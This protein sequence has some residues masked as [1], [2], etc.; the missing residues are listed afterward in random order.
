MIHETEQ[1]PVDIKV[2]RPDAMHRHP[3]QEQIGR[4]DTIQG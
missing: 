2:G 1:L 4:V 3:N